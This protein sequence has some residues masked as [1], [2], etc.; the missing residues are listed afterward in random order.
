M[1]TFL[2]HLPDRL[3]L[4]PRPGS[5]RSVP[6]TVTGALGLLLSLW[7]LSPLLTS[8]D[9]ECF[10]E[11]LQSLAISDMRGQLWLDDWLYPTFTE[12]LY[13]TRV[14][15]IHLLEWTMR[16]TGASSLHSFRLIMAASLLTAAVASAVVVRRW[17]REPLWAILAGLVLLPGLMESAFSFSD[18]LPSA[19][20]ALA[21]M[22]LVRP[23]TPVLRWLLVGVLFAAATLTRLDALLTL[24]FFAGLLVLSGVRRLQHTL[25]PAACFAAG[26]AALFLLS[27]SLTTVQLAHSVLVGHRFSIHHATQVSLRNTLRPIPLVFFGLLSPVLLIL[28]GVRNWRRHSLLW[29]AV[30][31][32]LPIGFYAFCTPRALQPRDFFLLGTPFLIL[33]SATGLVVWRDWLLNP[34]GSRAGRLRRAAAMAFAGLALV[35]FLAPAFM[36]NKDGPRTP[37]GRLWSPPLWREWQASR[38]SGLAYAGQVLRS[39]G[40][41]QRVYVLSS[42]WQPDS[43]FHLRLLQDGW[44]MQPPPVPPAGCPQL[45]EVYTRGERTLVQYR[46]EDPYEHAAESPLAL[47]WEFTQAYQADLD[48]ACIERGHYD[49]GY[50]AVWENFRLFSRMAVVVASG[51]PSVV[52]SAAHFPIPLLHRSLFETFQL[53]PLDPAGLQ[54]IR[55]DADAWMAHELKAKG[56]RPPASYADYHALFLPRVWSP[57]PSPS[58][59]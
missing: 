16:L 7:L 55:N 20:F 18:N 40:P 43:A 50:L 32:L 53:I 1:S 22:A 12:Y 8:S 30:L 56:E 17:A 2:R 33:H 52:R 37:V 5:T 39:V 13:T 51:Q 54:S 34:A 57:Q 10:T 41:G 24:P 6:A 21:G 48:V 36:V 23:G 49:H 26:A 47:D 45:E 44:S 15:L 11:R 35:T 25:L 38:E 9:I 29:N 19:A 46:A 3:R 42:S 14:G 58:A 59:R 28:G 4:S 31:L 27:Q